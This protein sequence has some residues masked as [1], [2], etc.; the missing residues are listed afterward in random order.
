MR[1]GDVTNISSC[2][3]NTTR[4]WGI[5]QLGISFGFIFSLFSYESSW[6]PYLWEPRENPS[7]GLLMTALRWALDLKKCPV[8]AWGHENYGQSLE[9]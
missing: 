8:F 5:R 4:K 3:V 7:P 2:R 9:S 1:C 6:R